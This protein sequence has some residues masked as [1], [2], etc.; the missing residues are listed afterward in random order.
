MGTR[1]LDYKELSQKIDLATG[2]LSA[3]VHIAERPS[4]LNSYE[5]VIHAMAFIYF[6]HSTLRIWILILGCIYSGVRKV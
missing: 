1:N 6:M 4:T 5:Q 3:S 2:G